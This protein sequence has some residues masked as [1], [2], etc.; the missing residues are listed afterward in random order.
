MGLRDGH[1]SRDRRHSIDRD[2]QFF[3][4]NL[5]SP[6]KYPVN[7]LV[8]VESI[9]LLLIFALLLFVN[10]HGVCRSRYRSCFLCPES[11]LTVFSAGD[12][13]LVL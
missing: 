7:S 3:Q 13:S 12:D 2:Q 11:D 9:L 8:R 4:N 6:S 5:Q 10:I 1:K